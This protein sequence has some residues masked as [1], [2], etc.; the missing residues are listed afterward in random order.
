MEVSQ[1]ITDIKRI[2]GEKKLLDFED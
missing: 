1:D 2:E